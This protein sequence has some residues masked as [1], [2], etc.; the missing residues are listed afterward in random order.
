[1]RDCF[2][3]VSICTV[4]H[5]RVQLIKY[6][7]KT[8][9][10]IFL[11]IANI[12]SLSSVET[13]SPQNR[14]V[15]DYYPI[16]RSSRKS[17]TEL[18]VMLSRC[19][20]SRS[21]EGL[22]ICVSSSSVPDLFQ[23]CEEKRHI[24]TLITNGIENGMMVILN[25]PT[26]GCWPSVKWCQLTLDLYVNLYRSGTSKERAGGFSP[27]RHFRKANTWWSTTEIYCRLLMPK[28]GRLYTHKIQPPA[29]TCITS[30]ISAKRI[31]TFMRHTLVPFQ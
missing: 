1:M 4:Y 12:I 24:D 27:P 21:M 18:K 10:E 9:V 31:G 8:L 15:T 11:I 20:P 19:F 2:E 7:F 22:S 14:K 23:Q 25:S 30:N 5:N 17:K 6:A 29:A 28:K 16:R 3:Q 26:Y 13:K